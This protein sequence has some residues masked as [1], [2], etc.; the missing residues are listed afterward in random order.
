MTRRAATFVLLIAVALAGCRGSRKKVIAVIPKGTAHLFWVS[1]QAGALAAGREL[2]VDVLWNGPNQ[3]NEYS[4]QIQ[5]VDSMIARRVDGIALA[6]AERTALVQAVDRAAAAGIP[7]T[8]FDSGLD[9]EN[10]MT[11]VATNNY[12]AGQLAARKLASLLGNRGKVAV[13]MH[14][15]GSYSTMERERGFDDVMAKEFPD[16]RVVARQFGMSDRAKSVAAAENILTAHPDLD[17][18]FASTEPSSSGASLALKA[19]GL[20]GK[21]KFVAFDTS[22]AMIED[23]KSGVIHATVVQDPFRIGYEAVKT[24][25]DKLHGKNPPKRI[26]L[27]GTVVSPENLQTMEIQQ[28]LRPNINKHLQK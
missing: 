28:L 24:L 7:V 23:I 11:F 14:A 18:I 9:S 3:E 27:G 22:D 26:D 8:I 25:V 17:G 10:Y 19:R 15:P 5:I 16:I 13:V 20:G 1:V 4:R 21:V 2:D 12:E 6:A